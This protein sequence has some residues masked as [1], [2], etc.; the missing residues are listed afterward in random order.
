MEIAFEASPPL[1]LKPVPMFN[2]LPGRF[3]EVVD[4]SN[5]DTDHICVDGAD[6]DGVVY[7]PDE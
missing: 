1:P 2:E 7:D 6:N 4:D 3:V 5:V